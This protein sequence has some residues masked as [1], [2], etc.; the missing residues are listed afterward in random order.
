MVDI[1]CDSPVAMLQD[2]GE[3]IH[4]AYVWA[5]PIMRRTMAFSEFWDKK[6]FPELKERGKNVLVVVNPEKTED[7]EWLIRMFEDFGF[8]FG[9][10]QTTMGVLVLKEDG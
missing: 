10:E 7:V 2:E 6:V 5:P 3:Y 9:S 1:I 8:E 4:L